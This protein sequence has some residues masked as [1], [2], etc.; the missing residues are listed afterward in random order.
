MRQVRKLSNGA[1]C[2]DAMLSQITSVVSSASF[3]CYGV[4]PATENT[5]RAPVGCADACFNR[6]K[7]FQYLCVN[8]PPLPWHQPPEYFLRPVLPMLHHTV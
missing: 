2:N 7:T 8:A 1:G 6:G 3:C 5:R 4:Y